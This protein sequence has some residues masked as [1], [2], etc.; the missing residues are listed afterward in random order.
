MSRRP[1]SG[2]SAKLR[3]SAPLFAA[4]AD[5]NRLSL[6][7]KLGEG[8]LLSIT[9]LAEG[10]AISRQAVT[11]HLRIFQEAGLVRGVRRGREVLFRLEPRPLKDAQDALQRISREWDQ[12]LARLKSLVET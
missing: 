3:R 5:E 7:V 8:S 10:S 6:L 2:A 9:R 11:K 12:A 1:R 4:L